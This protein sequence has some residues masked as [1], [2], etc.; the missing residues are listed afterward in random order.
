MTPKRQL[1]QCLNAQCAILITRPVLDTRLDA[2]YIFCAKGVKFK[3]GDGILNFERLEKGKP[4]EMT[5]CQTCKFYDENGGFVEKK[6][7]GDWP[8]TILTSLS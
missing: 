3:L 2:L 1:Y 5:E 4:L 8:E 6:D 7:R